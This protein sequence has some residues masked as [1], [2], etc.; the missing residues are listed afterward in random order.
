MWASIQSKGES[1]VDEVPGRQGLCA[2]G[3]SLAFIPS[4]TAKPLEGYKAEETHWMCFKNTT[5]CWVS[6]GLRG[7]QQRWQDLADEKIWGLI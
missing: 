6:S 5:G 3:M 1:G 7:P 2:L 4:V